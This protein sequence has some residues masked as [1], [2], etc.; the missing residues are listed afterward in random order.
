M[1][2]SSTVTLIAG[3]T[4]IYIH[5][6]MLMYVERDFNLV[7]LG[8]DICGLLLYVHLTDCF[9]NHFMFTLVDV[10]FNSPNN[11]DGLFFNPLTPR[12]D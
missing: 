11:Q 10:N 6:C 1:S 4:V 9:C 7:Q 2:V 12:S 5:L 8:A 3:K